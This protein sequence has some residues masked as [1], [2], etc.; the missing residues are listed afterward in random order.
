MPVG[1]HADFNPAELVQTEKL[2]SRAASASRA[3]AQNVQWTEAARRDGSGANTSPARRWRA[4]RWTYTRHPPRM[5]SAGARPRELQ[6]ALVRVVRE[7]IS[8]YRFENVTKIESYEDNVCNPKCRACKST[9]PP[10]SQ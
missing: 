7:A 8:E 4:A 5:S 1:L 3:D 9:R 10:F 2:H 6:Y